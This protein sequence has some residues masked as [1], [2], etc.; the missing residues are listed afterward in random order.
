MKRMH[1]KDKVNDTMVVETK[2]H[3]SRLGYITE[4]RQK[5]TWAGPR[6]RL[7]QTLYGDTQAEAEA[8]HSAGILTAAGEL[9]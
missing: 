8:N 1:R 6:G 4:V 9:A 2:W 5:T 3:D 7:V